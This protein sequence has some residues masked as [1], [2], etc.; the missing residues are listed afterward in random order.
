MYCLLDRRLWMIWD[1][2]MIT[3]V[4]LSKIDVAGKLIEKNEIQRDKLRKHD[5]CLEIEKE[6]QG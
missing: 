4:G 2:P 5:Q 1:Y 3:A 6:G